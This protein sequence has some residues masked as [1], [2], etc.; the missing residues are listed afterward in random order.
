[1][2]SCTEP[3]TTET[4]KVLR[5]TEPTIAQVK[6]GFDGCWQYVRVYLGVDASSWIPWSFGAFLP[7]QEQIADG[8]SWMRCD[9]IFPETWPHGRSRTVVDPAEGVADDPPGYLW[10]CLGQHPDKLEQPFVPCDQPHQYE[11]T[12]TLA[13]LDNLEQYP[14]A[15]ELASATRQQCSHDVQDK[16]ADVAVTAYWAPRSALRDGTEIVGACF[17]FNKTGQ[18]LA[19]RP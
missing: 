14:S 13:F 4:V 8:A 12:G 6:E 9:V 19:P 15:A 18:P 11:E 2:V 7:T 1:M 3:H 17:I 5:L 10:A 16:D